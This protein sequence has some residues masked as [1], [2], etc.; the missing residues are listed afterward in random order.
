MQGLNADSETNP[1]V[2]KLGNAVLNPYFGQVDIRDVEASP[3]VNSAAYERLINA[4]GR[5]TTG[6]DV[7]SLQGVLPD[8]DINRLLDVKAKRLYEEAGFTKNLPTNVTVKMLE[9]L[10]KKLNVNI[11]T[12]SNGFKSLSLRLTG[13][14][15]FNKLNGQQKRLVYSFL[16]TLPAHEGNVITLPDFSPR[17]YTLNEY[18]Q[19]VEVLN[20]G[21]TP[22]IPNI[23]A[24]LGL[25]PNNL[26]DKRVATRLR[27]DL[28]SAG[29]VDQKCS[30]YKF[31]ANGEWT[32]NSVEQSKIQNDPEVKQELKDI[33]KFRNL[34][35]A[36]F[37]KMNLPEVSV[38]LDKAIQT[39]VGQAN[40]DAEGQFDP[41]WSEVFLSVAKAK[42][43][44]TTE[45]E[46]L[47]NLS[48]TMGHELFHAAVFLDLF[49]P[50]ERANLDNYV[51]NNELNNKT[52]TEVLGKEQLN[53][54]KEELGRMPTYLEAVEYRYNT[55]DNQNLNSV[56]LLEEANALLFEDYI[57]NK[58]LSG[59]PKS[60]MEKTKKFFTSIN[61]GLNELGY[62]TYE[63]VFDKL[64]GG[65]IGTRERYGDTKQSVEVIG[66]DEFGSPTRNY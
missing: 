66:V 14:P 37:E 38:R 41:V 32:L 26:A 62:R 50:Q 12:K 63:D 36:S 29:I 4:V 34:L 11:D 61:N 25:N 19:V 47:D 31:N 13:Q 5:D 8:A 49:S 27:Q 15:N 3:N 57:E 48:K 58:K 65:E 45:Q 59:K 28:F 21:S 24:A 17:P 30:K 42:E 39:R 2:N 52:A 9:N 6:I 64:I 43:G 44:T 46:V 60:L 7:L 23:V 40:P 54:L 55:L 20:T 18:N 33:Q 10:G 53:I 51:R 22:T 16:S 35:G 56:D 1:F